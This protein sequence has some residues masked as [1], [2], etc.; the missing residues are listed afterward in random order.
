MASEASGPFYC[1]GDEKVYMD[2]GFFDEMKS[3]FGTPGDF[4]IAYVIA[5]KIGHHIQNQLGIIVKASRLKE[6]ATEKQAHR[7]QVKVELQAD[8]LAGV[9][10]HYMSKYRNIMEEGDTEEAL[11][12]TSV[13]GDDRLQ[14]QFQGR[15]VPD[16]FNHGTS[17]Q[18]MRWFKKGYQTGDIN[19][20]NTLAIENL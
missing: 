4:D 5:H 16:A 9:W 3:R 8:F 17:E 6:N 7:I 10:A 20:G 2:L 13:V 11:N 14:Q 1:P 19:E 12:A 15:V 18:R